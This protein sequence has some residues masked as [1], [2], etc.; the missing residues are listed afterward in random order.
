MFTDAQVGMSMLVVPEFAGRRLQHPDERAL[1]L[2]L[3]VALNAAAVLR[4]WP[5][6]EGTGWI[7]STRYWPMAVS[8]SL[9]L[10]AVGA[11]AG[12]FVQSYA[13]QRDPGWASAEALARR[14]Q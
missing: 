4:I 11:F 3:L 12:M 13:E 5:A 1:I 10:A 8:A 14:K 2:G 7:T 9:T 6:M